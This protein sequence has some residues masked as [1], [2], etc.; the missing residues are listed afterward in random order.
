MSKIDKFVVPKSRPFIEQELKG[1]G[2]IKRIFFIIFPDEEKIFI[3][4]QALPDTA[5]LCAMCDGTEMY[6]ANVGSKKKVK[7]QFLPL[8]WCINDWGSSTYTDLVDAM[9][10]RKSKM[11]EEMPRFREMLK[12]E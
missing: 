2:K 4:T 9:K 7:R 12:N 10:L 6:V 11:M 5:I 8:D 3:D 1:T